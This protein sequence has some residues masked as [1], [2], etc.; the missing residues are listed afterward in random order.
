MPFA[1]NACINL[2]H[3]R[4]DAPVRCCPSCGVVVNANLAMVRC[5]P[6]RHDVRRRTGS[7]FCVDCGSRLAKDR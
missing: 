3:R 6:A 5:P 2:N 1:A 7:I 4:R